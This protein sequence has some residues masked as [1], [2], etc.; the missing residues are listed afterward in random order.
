MDTTGVPSGSTG[1]E[2]RHLRAL[3]AIGDEGTVTGAAE[4]LHISQP[5]VSR[6]LEQLERAVGTRLV[7]RTTRS[8][9]LTD[10]GR[11]L[12]E[13][14]HGILNRL[15]SAL[16]EARSG[17]RPLRLG[18]AWGALGPDTVPL[19]REWRAA[20]PDT[21]VRI[22]RR[23]D[24]EKAL[25]RSEVDAVLLR[26][27]PAPGMRSVPLLYERRVA[28]F[29]EADPLAAKEQVYLADLAERDVALC[30]TA[31]TTDVDLWPE[32]RRPNAVTVTDV[33][34]WLAAIATGEAVGVTAEGS[35]HSH[36]APGVRYVPIADAPPV[37]AYLAWPKE[38]SHPETEAFVDHVHRTLRKRTAP[39]LR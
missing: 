36:P 10:E 14:A 13:H 12:W 5:A 3:A 35:A 16:A 17:P 34:E 2:L 30:A 29:A 20:H 39:G 6:T 19:L 9:A 27:S 11:R 15:D 37:A 38:P 22:H 7:E 21:P 18:I 25:R 4:V 28:A 1:V 32:G 24:P 23:N 33:E 31:A 8:L 26:A